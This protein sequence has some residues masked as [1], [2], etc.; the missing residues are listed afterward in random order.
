[1][2][3]VPLS[4]TGRSTTRLGYGCS[5]LMGGTG[6]RGSLDLLHTAFDAGIRHF[7]VAPSYG[8]GAAEG[9]LGDFLKLHSGVATVTTKY[10]IPP[11]RNQSLMGVAR[12]IAM[13]IVRALPGAKQRF[14]RLARVA[15]RP[16][17]KSLFNA[18]QAQ[19]SLERSLRELKVDRLDLWLLHEARASDLQDDSLLEFLFKSALEG[20]IGSFGVGSGASKIPELF[21]EKKA[22]CRT[23]QFEWSV[24][25]PV[26]DYLD[27]FRIHHRS[28][29]SLA[30]IRD[31]LAKNS[32]VCRR[33][34]DEVGCDLSQEK[35]LSGLMLKAALELN[36]SSII[37]FS[38]KRPQNIVANVAVLED[39]GLREGA[40]RLHAVVRRTMKPSSEHRL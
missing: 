1:M 12:G 16:V 30:T 39:R 9:A 4:D 25:D 3:S 32:D 5:S 6:Y 8:F 36:P 29:F 11:S 7:D 34:S 17:S 38:S 27:C 20:K 14:A 18:T 19:A 15:S 33:W 28:L 26:V 21:A 35:N 37:L 10:G 31:M 2:Q 24:M 23:L 22:Y 40:L 13:P